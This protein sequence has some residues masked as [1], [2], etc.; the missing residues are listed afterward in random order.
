MLSMLG[1]PTLALAS[2]TAWVGPFLDPSS[3]P[4]K[5]IG[6]DGAGSD[7]L[8]SRPRERFHVGT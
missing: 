3:L 6:G 1:A 7:M 8:E 5:L 4:K 2:I